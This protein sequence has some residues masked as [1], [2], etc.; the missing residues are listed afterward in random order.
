MRKRVIWLEYCY[1]YPKPEVLAVLKHLL[2]KYPGMDIEIHKRETSINYY[3][4]L[5]VPK[6]LSD[7]SDEYILAGLDINYH[8]HFR[9]DEMFNYLRN[10]PKNIEYDSLITRE[11]TETE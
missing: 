8:I 7:K 2:M 1:D 11:I 6:E 10:T 9:N 5:E 4:R 3:V